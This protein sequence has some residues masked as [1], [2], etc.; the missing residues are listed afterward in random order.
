MH[1]LLIAMASLVAEHG[2]REQV[3]E[4]VVH[5]LSRPM[6]VGSSWIRGGTHVSCIGRQILNHWTTREVLTDLLKCT[7]VMTSKYFFILFVFA[8]LVHEVSVQV[9]YPSKC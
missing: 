8:S 7:C 3:S 9:L 5:R 6:H 2:S 1:G 4:V